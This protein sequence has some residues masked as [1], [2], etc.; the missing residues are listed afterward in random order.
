MPILDNPAENDCY[1]C[2]PANPH[3]L[4]LRFERETVDGVDLVRCT[5]VPR[6]F[7]TGWPGL[8]HTGLH[9]TVLYDLSYWAA[10]E[11]GGA[12][13]ISAGEIVFNQVRLPRVG[14]STVATAWRIDDDAAL[15]IDAATRDD[16]GRDCGVLR[17][18]WTPASRTAVERAG[19]QLPG[20]LLD[21]MRP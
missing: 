2:G 21:A 18:A 17:T 13:M 11:F 4:Q 7:E 16:R 19:L 1:G 14:R 15:R 9:F 12:V 10:M 8:L 5:F 6:A 3:G 20:Y